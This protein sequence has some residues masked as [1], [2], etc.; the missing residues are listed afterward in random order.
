MT[1]FRIIVKRVLERIANTTNSTVN[2]SEHLQLLR[3]EIGQFYVAHDDFIPYQLD[4]P[5]GARIMTMFLY[6][7]DVEKG[8]GTRFPHL[9][10]TV[11]PKKGSALLWPNVIDED[12]MEM[13]RQAYHEAL[14]VEKGVKYGANAWIHSEDFQTPWKLKCLG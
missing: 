9:D 14:P 1:Y 10:I 2:H 12:P 3:Y 11:Q 13:Q 7:N 8:G 4:M 5:C 6:L